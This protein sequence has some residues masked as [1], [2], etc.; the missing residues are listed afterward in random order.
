MSIDIASSDV[1]QVASIRGSNALRDSAA[2]NPP[3]IGRLGNDDRP[4]QR[5][6]SI[7]GPQNHVR[8]EMFAELERQETGGFKQMNDQ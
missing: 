5:A 3:D 6:K 7:Q 1:N 4:D 8:S 2:N